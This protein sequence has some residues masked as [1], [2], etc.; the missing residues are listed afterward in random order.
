MAEALLSPPPSSRS[1][2]ENSFE[3]LC[4]C[5]NAHPAPEQVARIA[6]WNYAGFDW[7]GFIQLAEH[8]GVLALVASNLAQHSPAV[9]AEIAQSLR[10]AYAENLRRN[11]WFAGESA[12]ILEHFETRNV[13]AIPYKGPGLAQSAYGDLGLRSF[14][15]LDMLISPADFEPA[16]RALA[17]IGYHPSQELPPAVERLFLRTGYE[18]SFDG[19]AG[20]NLVELQWNLLP[21]LYAV[22]SR[23]ADSRVEDLLARSRQ[24]RLG[25]AEVPCL[26]P[27]DSLLVLCLHA[28][29][30]LWTRL[31]WLADIA[32]S[33]RAPELD[34]ALVVRRARAMG[35]ARILGVSCWLTQRL[36]GAAI[37]AAASELVQHD[38][39]VANLGEECA[40]RL[41]RAATYNFESSEYFRRVWRLRERASDRWRYLWRLAWTPGPG[42]VAS[43]EL[44]EVLFPLYRGVRIGRL[45]RRLL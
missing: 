26:S 12:R 13:R 41:A 27:E 5:A 2:Q 11:L 29:K 39:E 37:P 31:I 4:E 30:H 6:N 22:D 33:L 32:E 20:K 45:L 7:S 14:S 28:A 16:K 23:A 38:L 8:H 17:E 25:A 19:A 21:Y 36:L 44:P 9:P 1:A 18:R 15:D 35:I 42:E 3:L 43:V 10:S 34:C 40:V 24:L